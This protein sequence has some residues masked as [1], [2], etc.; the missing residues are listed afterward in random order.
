MTFEDLPD[1]WPSR[2]LGEPGFTA[3]LLD[4]CVTHGDRLQ[5]GLS[6]LICRRDAT[7]AQPVFVGEI[8]DED[9]LPQTVERLVELTQEMPDVGGVV[10]GF[11]RPWGSV[12]DR[13][14][15][16]HQHAIEVCG[17]A[18][19]RLLGTFVVTTAGIAHLPVEAGV[20]ERHGAA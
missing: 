11:V 4:L 1:D 5:C 18:G 16:L 10:L 14:R 3:D 9:E 8:P 19:V 17:R 7:L 2:P 20:V 13:D 15:A 6:V 12:T